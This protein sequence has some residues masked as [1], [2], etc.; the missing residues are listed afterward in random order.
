MHTGTRLWEVVV[1]EAET[2]QLYERRT[3]VGWAKLAGEANST[4][5]WLLAIV[6][7]AL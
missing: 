7:H 3:L 2:K 1:V 4:R 5:P 6:L